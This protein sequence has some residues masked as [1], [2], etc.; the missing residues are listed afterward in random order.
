MRHLLPHLVSING[1]HDQ[2]KP[3]FEFERTQFPEALLS[4]MYKTSRQYLLL[5]QKA[6]HSFLVLQSLGTRVV[7]EL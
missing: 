4:C 1:R 5:G 7:L 6:L 2:A 3:A